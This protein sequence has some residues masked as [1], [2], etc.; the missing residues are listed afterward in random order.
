MEVMIT[1]N[2]NHLKTNDE[3]KARNW[4]LICYALYGFSVVVFISIFIGLLLNYKLKPTIRGT[5]TESHF[6]WQIRT[7]WYTAIL[8]VLGIATAYINLGYL[9]IMGGIILLCTRSIWGAFR[10]YRNQPM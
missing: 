6:T 5:I 8:F 3:A 4:G 1:E 9:L 2:S 7:F 10:L